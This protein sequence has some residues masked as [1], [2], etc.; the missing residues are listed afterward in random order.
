MKSNIAYKNMSDID[1]GS[2]RDPSGFVFYQDGEVFR[3]INNY[4]KEDYEFLMKSG[5][6][7]ELVDKELLISHEEINKEKIDEYYY[8]IIKPEKIDFISY[9]YEWCF[10]QLKDAALLSLRIQKV[11]MKYGMSLKDC[12]A[13]NIQFLDGNPILIDT[14]SFEKYKEGHPWVAYRQFCQHFLAPL[15]L[16][17][18]KDIRLNQ[19]FKIYIDGIPLDLASSLLPLKSYFKLGIFLNI[20]LH[21][22]S[23]NYFSNKSVKI[24]KYKVNKNSL[25][26][27]IDSLESSVKKMKWKPRGTEW[28]D[29]YSFTNYSEESL[30]CKNKIVKDLLEKSAKKILWD[31]GSND[32]KFSRIASNMNILTISSDFD[33]AAVEKNYLLLKKNNDKYLLPLVIDLMNPSPSL[34][35]Q[36][37]ERNSFIERGPAETVLALALV[38]HLAISNN[39]PFSKIAYFFSKICKLLIIEFIPKNDSQVKKLL[40]TREDIFLNYNQRCFEKEFAEFF[41]IKESIKIINSERVIYLMENNI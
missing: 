35:W 14:L 31:L 6:Y 7:N 33:P 12:S 3:Q 18:Y 36:N 37:K 17:S 38:H 19:L 32:G 39:L 20:Y 40:D 11:A 13:Y 23:Q 28:A 21:S 25:L 27:I 15:A 24:K 26:G 8:K 2:F 16:M 29:Y 4:Y 9:P 30:K 5:L 1:F 10:S 22:R 41:K 34:G